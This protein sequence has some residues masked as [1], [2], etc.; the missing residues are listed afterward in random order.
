MLAA[1]SGFNKKKKKKREKKKKEER[2]H[3]VT[4]ARLSLVRSKIN[5]AQRQRELSAIDFPH[6]CIDTVRKKENLK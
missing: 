1:I 4:R 6:S 3:V 5:I 2:V